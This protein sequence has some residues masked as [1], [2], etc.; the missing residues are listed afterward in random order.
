MFYAELKIKISIVVSLRALFRYD[1]FIP[2]HHIQINFTY[3]TCK[4]TLLLIFIT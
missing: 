1:E 4:F 2:K 3:F